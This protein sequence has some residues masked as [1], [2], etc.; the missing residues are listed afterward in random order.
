[1]MSTL[2]KYNGV[3]PERLRKLLDDRGV[4][5]TELARELNISRQAVSQYADGTG[6]PNA[7]K[8][9]TIANFFSVSSDYLL[10]LTEQQTAD[11]DVQKMC[12]YTGLGE[13][14]IGCLH[15]YAQDKSGSEKGV[16]ANGISI[17]FSECVNAL[18][19]SKYFCELFSNICF[20]LIYGRN[21]QE[22]PAVGEKITATEWKRFMQWASSNG[23]EIIPRNDAKD[24][25]LQRA[26]D[27]FR[28]IC[29]EM[30]NSSQAGR[31]MQCHQ[32]GR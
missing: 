31:P 27:L 3:F 5:R 7:D 23:Q 4:T 2:E 9:K 17:S 26:C 8:L 28:N 13:A 25:Y 12:A 20:Y 1:M 10:G 29:T 19:T 24:L 14:A 32:H 16:T 22:N 15:Q 30:Q 11:V 6:Q 18:L 21:S